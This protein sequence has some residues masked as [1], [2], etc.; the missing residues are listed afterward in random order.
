MA[1]IGIDFGEDITF[2]IGCFLQIYISLGIPKFNSWLYKHKLNNR[3]L[4]FDMWFRN[5]WSVSLNFLSD[6][7]GWKKGGWRWYL[8]IDNKLKGKYKVSKKIIEERDIL[9]P[10]P[11]KSY[12]A[13][14]ILADWTWK[15]P[16]WF[17]KTVRRCEID[18]PEGIPHAGKGENSWDCGD[19]ATFGMTTGRVRSI[20]KAVGNLVGTVLNDRVRYGGWGDWNWKRKRTIQPK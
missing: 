6:T 20:A 2:S 10:M 5:G 18:V 15:Y 9:V 13:H 3:A 4:K 16:R 1:Q 8:N 12:R 7:M 17:P 19:T 14:A 11:E